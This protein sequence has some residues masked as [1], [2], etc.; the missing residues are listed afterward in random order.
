MNVSEQEPEVPFPSALA[1]RLIAERDVIANFVTAVEELEARV[2]GPGST[3]WDCFG[4]PQSVH[5]SG[6]DFGDRRSL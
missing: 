5:R 2:E 4:G 3:I 1:E 6:K